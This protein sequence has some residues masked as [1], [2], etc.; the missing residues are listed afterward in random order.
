MFDSGDEVSK[1][2]AS[3]IVKKLKVHHLRPDPSHDYVF[4]KATFITK[5]RP[6]IT[7][8]SYVNIS[9]NLNSSN[10]FHNKSVY[11]LEIKKL[12]TISTFRLILDRSEDVNYA[13]TNGVKLY[14]LTVK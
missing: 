11:K 2:F 3:E 5:H 13:S 4:S 14:N 6:F 7:D 8:N 9:N 1:F 12:G 10:P